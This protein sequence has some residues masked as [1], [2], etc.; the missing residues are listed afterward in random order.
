MLDPSVRPDAL[1]ADEQ[2]HVVLAVQ[3]TFRRLANLT[4]KIT[5]LFVAAG[6]TPPS[7]GTLARELSEK[8]E[9]ALVQH[10]A[11]FTPGVGHADLARHGHD[12]EVKIHRGAG[13]TIN[14]SKAVAGEHYLVVNYT[15]DVAVT[16]IW[17][18]WDATDACFT[19]R[20][21]NSNAR[22]LWRLVAADH[23][24]LIFPR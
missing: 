18:L 8:I 20:R 6:F 5:P 19:P 21:S 10:C 23:I 22:G 9:Q 4:T 12:W 16:G 11:T 14:Q 7:P 3:S 1:T 24:E 2:A 15:R 13:L 17:I